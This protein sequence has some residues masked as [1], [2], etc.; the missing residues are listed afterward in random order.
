M[1]TKP[2]VFFLEKV[3]VWSFVLLS[4]LFLHFTPES[5]INR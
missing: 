3:Y 1:N 4:E 2:I 5:Q